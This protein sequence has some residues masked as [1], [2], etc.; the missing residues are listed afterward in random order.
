LEVPG[1][2]ERTG[3]GPVDVR[4]AAQLL[5]PA[6]FFDGVIE[7]AVG[8]GRASRGQVVIAAGLD[9]GEEGQVGP[10]PPASR[11]DRVLGAADGTAKGH[12]G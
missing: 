11:P 2:E 4:P 7:S 5:G 1:Q 12:W 6:E 8:E 9:G 10:A 3:Q